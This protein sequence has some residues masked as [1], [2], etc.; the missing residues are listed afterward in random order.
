[1]NDKGKKIKKNKKNENSKAKKQKLENHK[2]QNV[3]KNF[4]KINSLYLI[5]KELSSKI[6]SKYNCSKKNMNYL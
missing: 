4:N 5:Q 1:M 2:S 3:N 6:Y